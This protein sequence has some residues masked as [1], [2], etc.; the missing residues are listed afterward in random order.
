VIVAVGL[1]IALVAF[2]FFAD[3]GPRIPRPHSTEEWTAWVNGTGPWQVGLPLPVSTPGTS[4]DDW[5]RNITITGTATARPDTTTFGRVVLVDGTGN[6][7]VRSSAIQY[8]MTGN[9]CCAEAF[10]DARW[11]TN[12]NGTIPDRGLW[13]WT[14]VGA[15]DVRITY[16]ATSAYCSRSATF[17]GPAGAGWAQIP[18]SDGTIC[19]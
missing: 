18:G 6:V 1:A 7:A 16:T 11:T 4:F 9:R 5:V 2:S 3:V 15:A 14:P 8:P 12:V 17:H 13:V 10:L 19:T